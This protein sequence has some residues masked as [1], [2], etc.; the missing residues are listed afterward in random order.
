MKKK[1]IVLLLV[2]GLLFVFIVGI[3]VFTKSIKLNTFWAS[4][5]EVKGVDVS[6]YQGEEKYIDCNVFA[7][8]KE[9]LKRLL[10]E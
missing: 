5:Y 7:G 9:E 1:R 8:T 6:H 10:L 4:K 3:G 2:V